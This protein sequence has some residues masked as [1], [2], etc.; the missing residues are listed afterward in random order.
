MSGPAGKAALREDGVFVCDNGS[1]AHAQRGVSQRVV[2]NQEKPE[3][4]VATAWSKAEGVDGAA[5]SDY[6]LYLDLTYTDGTPLWG[7]VDSWTVG[8]HDWEKAQVL[9]FPEK[10]VA[11]VSFY[12]LLRGHAG[13]AW[14]RDPQVQRIGGFLF[15]GVPVEPAESTTEGFQVRDVAAETDFV[16]IERTALDLTLDCHTQDRGDATFF[17]VTLRDISGKDRAVTLIYAVPLAADGGQWL[18]DPGHS[19]PV[20]ERREYV[21]AERFSAGTTGVCPA[22]RSARYP[23]RRRASAWASTWRPRRSFVWDTT[24]G[25]RSC[26]WLTTSA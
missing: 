9:V 10:P 6:S 12:M 1:D 22:I 18:R 4:I 26:S 24:P 23:A 13:K 17:D 25:R 5:D 2:L 7:Q 14:F 16:S 20:A 21:D 19:V 8:T 15:D 3:P 11:S